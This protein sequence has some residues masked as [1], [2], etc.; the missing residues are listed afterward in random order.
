MNL[1]ANFSNTLSA[2]NQC[3]NPTV[4][5]LTVEPDYDYQRSKVMGFNIGM[6]VEL[7]L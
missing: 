5:F 4:F 6:A 3:Q 2:H 1:R 7:T